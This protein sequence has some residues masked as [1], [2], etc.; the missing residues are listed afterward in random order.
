MTGLKNESFWSKSAD[1]YMNDNRYVAGEAVL[2]A[3]TDR[4]SAERGF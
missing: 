3:V 2:Q 1:T 4:L